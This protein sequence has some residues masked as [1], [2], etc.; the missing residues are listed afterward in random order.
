MLYIA[1]DHAGYTLKETIKDTFHA[2]DLGAY[3]HESCDYPDFGSKLGNALKPGDRGIVVC[4][5]GVGI[6][7]V[8]NK[9]KGV[10]C[11]LV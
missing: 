9:I 8:A 2:E 4:G 11:A 5:S 10:R 7:I 6:S 3:S 1:S